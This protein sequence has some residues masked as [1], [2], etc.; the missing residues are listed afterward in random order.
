MATIPPATMTHLL[1]PLDGS[2]LAEAALPATVRL[3][4]GLPARVTLLHVTERDAPA[5]V[6]GHHHLDDPAEAETYLEAWR[7]RLEAAGVGADCHVH[8]N[9]EGDVAR[10]IAEHAAELGAD[11]IVLCAHGEGGARGWW[12]GTMAQQTIRRAAPPVLLVRP[13]PGT[14][15]APEFAPRT[16]LVALDGSPEGEAALPDAA[17]LARALGAGLLLTRVVPTASTLGGDRAATAI[18]T[19]SATAAT[20]ELEAA[21]AREELAALAARLAPTGVPVRAEVL[22]GEAF[23]KL[24]EATERA[25]PSLLALATH[26]HAGLDALWSGSVGSRVVAK[27]T[28]P[29][30]LVHP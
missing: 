30:L 14:A 3:A 7:D 29:L 20:L 2:A 23:R 13:E 12:A 26:G 9:P 15:A 1:V 8:P 17:A 21:A 24:A 27:V 11:L 25:A 19:P 28:A 5:T 10:S 18:F 6:H 16:V 4:R 22:R